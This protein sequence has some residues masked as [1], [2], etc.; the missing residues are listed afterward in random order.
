VNA[1]RAVPKSDNRVSSNW[2][3]CT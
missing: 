3:Y 2:Y 1:N